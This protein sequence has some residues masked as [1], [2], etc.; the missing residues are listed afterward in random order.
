[1]VHKGS[2]AGAIAISP[3]SAYT[4]IHQSEAI[5]AGVCFGDDTRYG[6]DARSP[7]TFT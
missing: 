5:R 6:T 1:M 7:A 4:V 3:T 2:W